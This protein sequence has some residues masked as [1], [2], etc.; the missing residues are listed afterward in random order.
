MKPNGIHRLEESDLTVYRNLME[1]FAVEF[2]E[3]DTY[4][5]AKPSDSYVRSLL[6]N[7]DIIFLTECKESVV[8]GGLVAYILKKFEQQR[9]EIYIYDLAVRSGWRRQGIATRLIEHLKIIAKSQGAWVIFVQADH[10]DDP[11]IKLYES[12]G[13]REEVLH[14]DIK[15]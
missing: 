9:S 15:P 1:L 2:E 14:F 8:T 13:V 12:L 6:R 5:G 7:D 3:N 10:G 4:Q 11:A